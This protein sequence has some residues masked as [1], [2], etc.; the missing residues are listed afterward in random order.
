V[1]SGQVN[2]LA[3]EGANDGDSVT[4][5]IA[6]TVGEEVFNETVQV[7]IVTEKGVL[8]GQVL[9]ASDE[10]PIE[11]ATVNIYSGDTVIKTIETDENGQYETEIE[12]GSYTVQG[13]HDEYLPD[14]E[15]VEIEEGETATQD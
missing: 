11:G 8:Q 12:V 15:A 14:E 6:Y 10:T 4:I 9:D 3:A 1:E 5:D 2:V 7:N 13:T